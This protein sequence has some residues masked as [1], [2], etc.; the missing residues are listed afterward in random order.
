MADG[1]RGVRPIQKLAGTAPRK[2]MALRAVNYV[3]A[4]APTHKDFRSASLGGAT[5]M[6]QDRAERSSGSGEQA[7]AAPR[8]LRLRPVRIRKPGEGN[9]VKRKAVHSRRHMQK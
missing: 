5:P 1:P 7:H 9:Q 6:L 4:K 8:P 2:E 3:G